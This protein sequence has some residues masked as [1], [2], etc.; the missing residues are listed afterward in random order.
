M[1][2][3][4]W[5]TVVLSGAFR[6]SGDEATANSIVLRQRQA[7]V[8]NGITEALMC[9]KLDKDT[10]PCL[11]RPL[12]SVLRGA[13]I[14]SLVQSELSPYSMSHHSSELRIPSF[15]FSAQFDHNKLLMWCVFVPIICHCLYIA[16]CGDQVSSAYLKI[17]QGMQ[18]YMRSTQTVTLK[19]MTHY[20]ESIRQW[21]E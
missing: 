13:G 20:T 8:S 1:T 4:L 11:G 10:K 5:A 16:Y 17:T 18:Q 14:L 9:S 15:M 19:T 2:H 7:I 21:L 3:F 12:F 6:S